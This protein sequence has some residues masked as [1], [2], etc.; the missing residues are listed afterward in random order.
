MPSPGD[1]IGGIVDSFVAAKKDSLELSIA[2]KESFQAQDLQ[3]RA[4]QRLNEIFENSP[5]GSFNADQQLAWYDQEVDTLTS[6][7]SN[8][9]QRTKYKEL[10]NRTRGTFAIN[11]NKLEMTSLQEQEVNN[12]NKGQDQY[13]LTVARAND[14]REIDDL[15]MTRLSSVQHYKQVGSKTTRDALDA[16][17][18]QDILSAINRKTEI[19]TSALTDHTIS[20]EKY[21]SEINNIE[22]NL[23]NNGLLDVLDADKRIAAIGVIRSIKE[24]ALDAGKQQ[25]VQV[26]NNDFNGEIKRMEAGFAPNWDFIN[27]YSEAARDNPDDLAFQNNNKKLQGYV[28]NREFFERRKVGSLTEMQGLVDARKQELS[29]GK[30]FGKDFEIKSGMLATLEANMAKAKETYTRNSKEFFKDH[31]AIKQLSLA[32]ATEST[33]ENYKALVNKLTQLH[34]AEGGDPSSIEFLSDEELVETQ[35]HID[36]A[37]SPDQAEAIYS[38]ILSLYSASADGRQSAGEAILTQLSAS[39]S[40]STISGRYVGTGSFNKIH[41]GLSMK[42]ETINALLPKD[43]KMKDLEA[44]VEETIATDIEHLMRQ[45]PS[46]PGELFVRYAEA[47]RRMALY[48]FIDPDSAA[49][50]S[51]D[52]AKAAKYAKD[53]LFSNHEELI[54]LNSNKVNVSISKQSGLA[55]RVKSALR[56]PDI[57]NLVVEEHL[58]SKGGDLTLRGDWRSLVDTTSIQGFS[59][60][61]LDQQSLIET[62]SVVG[63]DLIRIQSMFSGSRLP[64]RLQ[65]TGLVEITPEQLLEAVERKKIEADRVRIERAQKELQEAFKEQERVNFAPEQDYGGF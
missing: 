63:S 30:V 16:Q 50:G 35:S 44:K 53:Q 2:A 14:I 17:E 33:P 13:S 65:K 9:T 29:G 6:G 20:R 3:A 19:L 41:T 36:N 57:I 15:L 1:A 22:K 27:N 55:G 26:L 45:N 54:E 62:S 42:K 31:P 47:S 18:D 39:G 61:S 43:I 60:E 12:L 48:S 52:V 32:A 25:Q 46:A 51:T 4:T 37:S 21:A 49:F 7:I 23:L 34:T 58:R 24:T 28:D 64:L 56:R 59:I 10:L 8:G 11:A 40:L 5:E 38:N